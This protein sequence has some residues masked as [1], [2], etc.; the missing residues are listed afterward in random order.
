MFL[1]RAQFANISLVINRCAQGRLCPKMKYV[2]VSQEKKRCFNDLGHAFCL[3][4]L[5]N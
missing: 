1:L 4:F 3:D 2:F 5:S